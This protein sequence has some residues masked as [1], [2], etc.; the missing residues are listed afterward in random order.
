[1]TVILYRKVSD[2]EH[3]RLSSVHDDDDDPLVI[4]G[5]WGHFIFTVEFFLSLHKLETKGPEQSVWS[6]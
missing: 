2:G 3:D 6:E 5:Q 4:Y 1:M